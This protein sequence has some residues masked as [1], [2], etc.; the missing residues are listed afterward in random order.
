MQNHSCEQQGRGGEGER[1]EK[2]RRGRKGRTKARKDVVL[3]FH[4]KILF[5]NL[6]DFQKKKRN[7]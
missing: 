7:K 6:S 5:P 2:G 3:L 1:G 4:A